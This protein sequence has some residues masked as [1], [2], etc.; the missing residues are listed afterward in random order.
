MIEDQDFFDYEDGSCEI[1]GQP[2]D[3]CECDD[4]LDCQMTPDGGCLK[5]GSEECDECPYNPMNEV[6]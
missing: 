3:I 4:D 2:I 1:C 6:E 5:A